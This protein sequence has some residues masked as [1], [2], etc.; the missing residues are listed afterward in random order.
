LCCRYERNRLDNAG[1]SS[2]QEKPQR[3]R[4]ARRLTPTPRWR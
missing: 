4:C 3:R 2:I 1:A